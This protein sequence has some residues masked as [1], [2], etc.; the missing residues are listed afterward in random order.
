ML[1]RRLLKFTAKV[2]VVLQYIIMI[3]KK[4]RSSVYSN[5]RLAV[6]TSIPAHN[7]N[8]NLHCT[9][10]H[11]T[12]PT[13]YSTHNLVWKFYRS[14]RTCVQFTTRTQMV[15]KSNKQKRTQ[16]NS[17]ST[18]FL[19]ASLT[20]LLLLGQWCTNTHTHIWYILFRTYYV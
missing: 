6:P 8:K 16:H 15:L 2:R 9:N 10:P 12:T 13:V 5:Q 4:Q 19:E 20:F 14:K 7:N 1:K 18:F 3:Y 17:T 11:Y